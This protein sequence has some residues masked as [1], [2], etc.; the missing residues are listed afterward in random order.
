MTTWIALLYSITV[1]DGR[2]VRMSDLRE[3]ARALGFADPVTLLATGNLIFD[4]TAPDARAVERRL[5]PAFAEAFGR[6]VPI[7]VRAGAEWPALLGGNPFPDAAAREPS[8]VSVRIMRT[9]A[10]PDVAER[11]APYR[12][13]DERLA[14]VDGDLWLHLPHGVATS[15]LAAAVTPKR[16]GG[17][18]TF[19]NWNTVRRIADALAARGPAS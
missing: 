5:E 16:A 17:V 9:A 4:A 11:L 14:V 19:R 13:G 8:R 7:V 12:G 3:L 2:R 15:R 1:A 10:G 18:G 6:A